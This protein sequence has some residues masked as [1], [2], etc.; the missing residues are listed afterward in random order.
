MIRAITLGVP[1][2]MVDTGSAEPQL[3]RFRALA[4]RQLAARN[5]PLR[6]LRLTLPPLREE[7][8]EEMFALPARLASFSEMAQRLGSRWFCLPVDLTQGE[9]Y[10]RRLDAAFG[11]LFKQP[12]M[13]L[14]LMVADAQGIN[15]RASHDVARFML[16]VAQRSNNGF[17]NF[18]VGASLCCPA[19]APFFPF[20]RHEGDTLK[21]SF[22]LETT[23][24]ALELSE[25]VRQKKRS[26]GEFSDEFIA[27]LIT[28]LGE[29]NAFGL[30]LQAATGIDYAGLDASL[31]P[32]PDGNISV[33][34]LLE[35]LGARPCGSQGSLFITSILTNAIKTA[36][37]RSGALAVGFNG[38]MFSVLE[39]DVLASAN[40]RRA[41]SVDTLNGWST[42]CGCGLDMLPVPG[43]TL[44][45]DIAAII[46]DTAA[47]A[48]RLT[49]PL[50]V[51]LL[52]IP[53]KEVNELTQFNFDFLC[54][55]RVMQI[56]K[57][58]VSFPTENGRWNYRY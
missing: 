57:S 13:F 18:R 22:A 50:G 36:V 49:K 3:Q 56:D 42:V 34:R 19:N 38:V 30:E 58:D 17:D 23:D 12:R 7:H 33:G 25:L 40:N 10:Q 15:I 21:F 16:N 55:S 44:S 4:E 6:T 54:N 11:T 20:S 31:A 46:L 29:I 43:S 2:H 48:V 53:G 9:N 47:L 26:L 1:A 28:R 37:A 39:D 52:P 32:F 41:L 51:R 5:W 45:E 14:N 27:R 24:I 35:N 8:E